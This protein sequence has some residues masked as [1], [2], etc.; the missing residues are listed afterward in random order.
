MGQ[1]PQLLHAGY[2]ASEAARTS[3]ALGCLPAGQYEEAELA[4]VEIFNERRAKGQM[5]TAEWLAST[6]RK[7]ANDP[8]FKASH[9][10]FRRFIVR[11]R[12]SPRRKK[13]A[14][15]KSLA[16]RLPAIAKW[17][18]ELYQNVIPA[19]ATTVAKRLY[20]DACNATERAAVF[21]IVLEH[22]VE[23]DTP[24]DA[25]QVRKQIRKVLGVD[26]LKSGAGDTI[27]EMI[28]RLLAD[29]PALQSGTTDWKDNRTLDELVWGRFPGR[30]N[31]RALRT[32]P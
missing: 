25:A 28:R 18:Y 16:E 10:W 7:Q 21:A 11:H 14:K 3:K 20:G 9:G 8:D 29:Q 23:R 12:L 27:G 19:T 6:M 24:S 13:N 15:S 32:S 31:S 4:V 26:R 17:H 30:T 5:V 22:V 1:A 2:A